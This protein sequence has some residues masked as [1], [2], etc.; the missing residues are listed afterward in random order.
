MTF[1]ENVDKKQLQKIMLVVISVLTLVAIALLLVIIISSAV[2]SIP[3]RSDFDYKTEPVTDKMLSTG[4]LILADDDHPYNYTFAEGELAVCGVYRNQNLVKDES[5][6][7]LN[8]YYMNSQSQMKLTNEAMAAAHKLLVAAEAAIQK[9]ELCIDSTYGYD[10][11]S[12]GSR[13]EYKTALLIYL[14][15]IISSDKP[16]EKLASSYAKWLDENAAKYGFVESF[17][18][19]YRY[20]GV[21]HAKYMTDKKLSLADYIA[22]LK[23]ETNYNTALNIKCDDATYSVY[24]IPCK[25]GDQVKIPKESEGEVTISGTNEG[26]LIVTVKLAK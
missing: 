10:D 13:E 1:L 15:R 12:E 23:R 7:E 2:G 9:D 19:G 20:V 21:A 8:K 24:Y 14:A 5:G 3:G 18:D 25:E 22:Y 11:E 4:T 6:K 16:N 26:G 17:E